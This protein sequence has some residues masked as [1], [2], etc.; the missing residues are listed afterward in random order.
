MIHS[1]FLEIWNKHKID[2]ILTNREMLSQNVIS[3]RIV[4]TGVA[5]WQGA[6]CPD[7]PHQT[8]KR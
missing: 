3:L 8:K 7:E 5:L 6:V 4:K 2:F 1:D